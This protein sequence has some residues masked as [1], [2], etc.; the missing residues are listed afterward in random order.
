MPATLDPAAPDLTAWLRAGDGV[1]VSQ[2]CAEPTALVEAVIR[3]AR[4]GEVGGLRLFAGMSFTDAFAEAAAA[5]VQVVSYGAL[6]RTGKVPGLEVIACHYSAIASLFAAGRLPGDVVLLQVS[7]PDA[8]GNCSLGPNVDHI[9]DAVPFSR[10]VIAEVNARCPRTA[11]A[12]V[13]YDRLDAV[14]HTDRELLAAPPISPGPVEQAIAAHVAGVVE[15]GDTIQLGVGAL[16]EAILAALRSHADLGVHTGMISDGVES[17]ITAGVVTNGRKPRDTGITVTG[18]ALGSTALLDALDGREDIVFRPASLTH[19]AERLAHVGRLAAINSALQVDLDGNAGSES[20][21][22]RRIGAVGGQADFFRAAAASGGSA[23]LALQ[24]KRIVE[25][26]DG[27]VS[28][29]RADVDWVVTENGARS[30][31]GLTDG[32]R[33][34]ALLELRGEALA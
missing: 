18:A 29:T 28:V 25:R 12:F 27:P 19:S 15:D 4:D 9:A 2:C 26:L 17:L 34:A 32:A 11:G 7:P 24:G 5:G 16:P 1:A 31:R 13:E 30:L 10:V 14:L 6:G 33:R 23:I 20:A 8:D 21:G 3:A 22:G